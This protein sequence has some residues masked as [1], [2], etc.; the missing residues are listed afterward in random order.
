[1]QVYNH[2]YSVIRKKSK[3]A[4]FGLFLIGT[5]SVTQIKVGFSI[6]ISEIFV[7]ATAPFLFFHNF[8]LLKQH[9]MLFFIYLG[10][11]VSVACVISGLY[12]NMPIFM[13]CKGLASTYPLFAFTVV[14]HHLLIK[15]M[16]GHKWLF[17]G[18][19]L[20]MVINVFAF[21]TSFEY[22]MYAKGTADAAESIASGPIFWIGRLSRFLSLPYMGWYLQTPTVY[23]MF[24]PVGLAIFAMVTSESGRA[25]ALGAMGACFI[26][27]LGGK[28]RRSMQRFARNFWAIAIFGMIA[29]FT[30]KAA[31]D[32][33]GVNGLLNER[34]L[35]K[36]EEQTSD[37][38]GILH[39]L[40]SGRSEVFVGAMA[41]LDKPWIGHG[42]W[43]ID[44]GG[45]RKKFLSKY[46]NDEDYR[47]FE[48]M[49]A[50]YRKLGI[51]YATYIPAHSHIVSFWL[52]FGVVGLF[53]WVYVFYA[54]IRFLRKEVAAIPQ[55]FGVLAMGAPAM[56][57]HLCFSGF[58]YRIMTLP[59]VVMLIMAH[60]IYKG[61]IKIPVEMEEEI[62]KYE[63]KK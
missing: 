38:K 60:N 61:R 39:L 14:L 17:L 1:M 32:Y 25:A 12:N 18:L 50:H 13:I 31:Y 9:G 47:F 21:H 53:Y 4:A 16:T 33:M 19:A 34:A 49:Q 20:S 8:R 43:A 27:F 40:M 42:P 46:G 48:G 52:W 44:D 63:R 3:W 45:Y 23:S 59:Y 26:A 56:L 54:I 10:I 22:E 41:A 62:N 11:A 55:W 57:W 36:F 7:Y 51:Y 58:G 35:N 24:A 5:F 30:F 28:T 29:V 6:G 37:G 2:E 15:N